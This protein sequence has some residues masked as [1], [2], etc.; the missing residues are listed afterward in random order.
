[1]EFS[2]TAQRCRQDAV[3]ESHFARNSHTTAHREVYYNHEILEPNHVKGI[4][5]TPN[6]H[7]VLGHRGV[8][9][10]NRN[11]SECAGKPS[12]RVTHCNHTSNGDEAE[13]EGVVSVKP[14]RVV[15]CDRQPVQQ[16]S[17][18]GIGHQGMN[19]GIC[20]K[21]YKVESSFS[22]Y[23]DG[24]LT[25]DSRGPL[26]CTNSNTEKRRSTDWQPR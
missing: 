18:D 11:R 23:L 17:V 21:K 14:Q 9:Y 22:Y 15:Q 4:A 24:E 6:R 10:M 20:P 12:S 26:T 7:E 13:K 5:L 8:L 1:M 2:Y 25:A 19:H 16:S 3:N